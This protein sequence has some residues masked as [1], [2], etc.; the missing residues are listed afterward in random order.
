[1]REWQGL[2]DAGKIETP[3]DSSVERA[4]RRQKKIET[5]DTCFDAR[6]NSERA[7]GWSTSERTKRRGTARSRK[8]S[9][10]ERAARRRKDRDRV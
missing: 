9:P 6:K 5:A 1:V 10:V 7:E 2:L 3:D 4:A 8:T